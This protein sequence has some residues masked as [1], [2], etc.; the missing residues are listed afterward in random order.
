MFSP[1]VFLPISAH[2]A[3]KPTLTG[4]AVTA[5]LSAPLAATLG[6]QTVKADSLIEKCDAPVGTLAVDEINN[7][8]LTSLR[9]Y[10]LQSP[11]ALIRMMVQ[12]SKCFVVVERGRAM[13]NMRQERALASGED[14]QSGSNVGKGQMKA[15]DFILTPTINF[16]EGNAGGA[17]VALGALGRKLGVG[18]AVAGGVKFKEASTAITIVDARSSV[19]IAAEEGVA[20]KGSFALG[21][22]ALAG[23]GVGGGGYSNTNEGKVIAASYLDNWNRIVRSVRENSDLM[24]NAQTAS[25]GL[26]GRDVK[27]GTVFNEGDVL[28]PKIAGVKLLGLPKES[29]RVISTLKR[30]DELVFMGEEKDDFLKVQSSDAEGWV[31]KTLVV[32]GK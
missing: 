25:T 11:T 18:G 21:G 20:K 7:E 2:R 32:K 15:A 24:K 14:L 3:V 29:G 19:Q 30:T 22:L 6:A 10:N 28:L 17:G 4:L 13:A 26:D 23:L 12:K 27:A 16:S 31:K 1:R 8:M 5:A 9:Y